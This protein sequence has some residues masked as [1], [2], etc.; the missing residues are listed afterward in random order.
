[1]QGTY[2]V[3]KAMQGYITLLVVR[4]DKGQVVM[5]LIEALGK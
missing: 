3:G 1:L 2:Y 4:H 5:K